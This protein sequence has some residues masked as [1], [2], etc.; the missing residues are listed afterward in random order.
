M[1]RFRKLHLLVG[2][3]LIIV[4][5]QLPRKNQHAI[6]RRAQL[7]GH[8]GQKLRFVFRS[9]RQLLSLFFHFPARF[10]NF[11]VLGFHFRF[12]PGQ[13]LSFLLQFFVVCCNSSCWLFNSSSDSRSDSACCSSC[14]LVFFSSSCW[15]CSSAAS[16]CDCCSKSS[17]RVLAAIVFNT[18]PILSVNWSRKVRWVSLN[19]L[20]VESSITAFT[21]PSKS[22]GR[23]TILLGGASPRPEATYT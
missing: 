9:K 11:S 16:D 21:S 10:L 20:K 17:V 7:V 5:C 19:V 18:I 23:T 12:L 6:E 8:I 22:T 15:L 1:D 4:F 3:V 14:S 13:Q 2:K